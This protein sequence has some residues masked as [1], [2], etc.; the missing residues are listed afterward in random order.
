MKK[1]YTLCFCALLAAGTV[2]VSCKNETKEVVEKVDRSKDLYGN[3][4]GHLFVGAVKA[5]MCL[6]IND[7]G[8]V[9][10]SKEMT[11]A[12]PLLTF[13][14]L[15]DGKWL[16][17]CYNAGEED[18]AK[19]NV[20]SRHVRLLADTTISPFTCDPYIIPMGAFTDFLPLTKG[21]AYN[22]EYDDEEDDD[23]TELPSKTYTVDSVSFDMKEIAAVTGA[24]L[25]Y[26]DATGL[27]DFSDNMPYTANLTAYSIG[28]TEVT[29]ELWEKVMGSN[30]SFF[31][32]SGEQP[33][34]G[35]EDY[36]VDTNVAAGEEQKKRP[37][38]NVSFFQVITFCNKL[39]LKLGLEPC[40]TVKVGGTA[41]DFET[42][43][44]SDIPT[45]G[46]QDWMGVE[47]DM[48]KN[49]F[50][51]PTEAE[52]EWA[53]KGGKDD[54][55]Y[56]GT[57]KMSALK[58]YAWYNNNTEGDA[59]NKTHEVKKKKQNGY[60]LYDMSGNVSEICW[61]VYMNESP[62]D[63]LTDPTGIEYPVQERS[64][65]SMRGGDWFFNIKAC[66]IAM[67]S[68]GLSIPDQNGYLGLRLVK[69]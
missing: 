64:N 33:V 27:L 23:I 57:D 68:P 56:A 51:L 13:K 36:L 7:K 8:A 54:A 40:Y 42:F 29:Q 49:G 22:G 28:E 35:L 16:I 43:N 41:I 38:E 4:W 65:R 10:H 6:V 5:E 37:V 24:K 61:D 17:N 30:P 18:L 47:M 50:R 69:R 60:G 46:N 66:R 63:G 9:L 59:D 19:N 44:V 67:R 25:G 26:K 52:W 58:N 20:P 62:E 55:V 48:S 45:D 21:K 39:S 15:G 32:N 31:N 53:A 14:D 12:Y 1:L 11:F 2:F 34:P 3:Y